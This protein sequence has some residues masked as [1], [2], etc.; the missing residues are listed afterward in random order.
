M[1]FEN[2]QN[3]QEQLAIATQA[4][5]G[6]GIRPVAQ[7][8]EISKIFQLPSGPFVALERT[9]LDFLPR[10]LVA[11]TGRSGSGKS[12]LIHLLAGLDRPSSGRVLVAGTDLTPMSESD[13]ARFRGAHV[14][15][16]F[17]FFQLL[18]TLSVL[19]N[20]VLAMELVGK[21]PTSRRRPRALELL[22]ILR[23]ADQAHKFPAML[24]GG[25]QQRAAIARAL[26]NDPP[27]IVADEPTGNLD[28][29][30][31]NEVF[32]VLRQLADQGKTVVVVTHE[33][34]APVHFDRVIV[35]EDGVVVEALASPGK[36]P[37]P[38]PD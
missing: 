36:G 31:A 27:I 37:S 2:I 11:V 29:A 5:A 4:P 34:A 32:S 15:V 35:L 8:L 9:S 24:S 20:I 18:P 16:V 6:T 30:T 21:V 22:S 26:A 14:G 10:E 19:E 7:L 13:L 3:V 28:T 12:T 38:C 1:V 17:Q 33:R 25:Q 23:I